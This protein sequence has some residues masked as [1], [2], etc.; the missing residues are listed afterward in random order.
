L[1][2]PVRRIAT[3]HYVHYHAVND[4]ALSAHFDGP[5]GSAIHFVASRKLG[6]TIPI[7]IL[8]R[9]DEVAEYSSLLHLAHVQLWHKADI[10]LSSG[11]VR[12][13]G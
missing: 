7:P 10:R 2:L 9:G 4:G 5:R 1:L 13:W 3:P 6:I 11:N 8:G 12:F